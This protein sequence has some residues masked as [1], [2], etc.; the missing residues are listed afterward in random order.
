MSDAPRLLYQVVASKDDLQ[1]DKL[2][3]LAPLNK[4]AL[5]LSKTALLDAEDARL[6]KGTT[7]FEAL[8]P[9]RLAVRLEQNFFTDGPANVQRLPN[10]SVRLWL[11]QSQLSEENNVQVPV[12]ESLLVENLS[13]LEVDDLAEVENGF[14]DV[15]VEFAEDGVV[16]VETEVT[17]VDLHLV[18]APTRL[19]FPKLLSDFEEALF[20]LLLNPWL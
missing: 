1:L 6:T 4:R 3:S 20:D 14:D 11:T 9:V 13:L 10:R 12:I 18:V 19:A 7:A 17:H 5:D 8:A 16:V 2:L 15:E